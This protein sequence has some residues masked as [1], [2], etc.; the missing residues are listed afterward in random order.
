MSMFQDLD[1]NNLHH[2]YLI[3]GSREEILPE[4]MEFIQ[5]LGIETAGNPDFSSIHLDSFKIEDARNLR[6]LSG[7]RGYSDNKKVFL[8]S[9]NSF[10][11]EAQNTLLK[12]FEEP[13]ENTIFFLVVPDKNA[14]L[15]TLVS[16]F[17]SISHDQGSAGSDAAEKF[18]SMT[19][20]GRIDFIKELLAEADEEDRGADSA[21]SKALNFLNSLE[22]SLSKKAIKNTDC[23]E[24]IFQVRKF[25][26]M[27]GSSAKMLMES[28]ALVC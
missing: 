18:I 20:A 19:P 13:I 24:Q 22:A 11:L 14:L 25:L 26:R 10:L 27:P 1:K 15:K 6:S 4:I 23:A 3:E 28:I 12:M 7:E 21:R 17:Y 9:A 2:A 5:G 16:R 8:L